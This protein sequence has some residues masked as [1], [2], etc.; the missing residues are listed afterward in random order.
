[1]TDWKKMVVVLILA[2]TVFGLGYLVGNRQ[3]LS[4]KPAWATQD[5]DTRRFYTRTAD[6]LEKMAYYLKTIAQRCRR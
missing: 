6:S 2:G 1:M 4:P 3:V 5:Y